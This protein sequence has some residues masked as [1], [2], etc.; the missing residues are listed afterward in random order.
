[1]TNLKKLIDQLGLTVDARTTSTSGRWVILHA[2]H[3]V[4][5]LPCFDVL[6]VR[7]DGAWD[8]HHFNPED[9]KQVTYDLA[10]D[11]CLRESRVFYAKLSAQMSEPAKPQEADEPSGLRIINPDGS[12]EP[13]VN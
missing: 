3:T 10:R 9:S 2:S 8:R 11:H 1:M 5:G 13:Y 6:A 4:S 7:F 12:E